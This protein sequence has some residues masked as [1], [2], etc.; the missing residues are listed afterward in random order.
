MRLLLNGIVALLLLVFLVYLLLPTPDFPIQ[1]PDSV[2]SLE[3]ADTETPLRRAYFTNFSREEVLAHYQR[4]FAS[5]AFLGIPQ[6]T[7]RLNYPPEDAYALIRDQTRSTFLE[8][9]VRPFRESLFV[10][11]FKPSQAK[12][13]I[14]YKGVH[15][16]QKITVGY[17]PSSSLVRVPIVFLAF[18]GFFAVTKELWDAVADLV[19]DW[20]GGNYA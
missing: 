1:P 18:V 14:W 15:Y 10:N 11:G 12:D 9:I 2:Q 3:D 13:D 19:K 6:I 7:Y 20:F 17:A 5:S 4:Q 8:E 16:E